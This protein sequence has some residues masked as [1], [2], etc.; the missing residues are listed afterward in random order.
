MTHASVTAPFGASLASVRAH[1]KYGLHKGPANHFLV[2]WLWF[3]EHILAF[4]LVNQ[5]FPIGFPKVSQKAFKPFVG[6]RL[7]ENGLQ[8]AL[9]SH[10]ATSR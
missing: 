2:G 7:V 9:A 3:P 8:K 5:G 4:P 10:P 6:L 1:L